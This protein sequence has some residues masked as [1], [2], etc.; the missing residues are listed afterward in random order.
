MALVRQRPRRSTPE[1]SPRRAAKEGVPRRAAPGK[2]PR[3]A[4]PPSPA[5]TSISKK[6]FKSIFFGQLPGGVGALRII[7][8]PVKDPPAFCP[9]LDERACTILLRAGY[10]GGKGFGGLALG[11]VRAGEEPAEPSALHRHGAA[12]L[13]ALLPGL[14]L[15]FDGHYLAGIVGGEV[16]GVPA[17]GVAGAGEELPPSAPFYDHVS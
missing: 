8:T 17:L 13:G 5:D 10:S 9:P 6:N 14:L 2:R 11:V 4:A 1:N 16:P 15:P 12:A 3:R 7:G